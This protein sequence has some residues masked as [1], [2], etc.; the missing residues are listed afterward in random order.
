LT[1]KTNKEKLRFTKAANQI[2]KIVPAPGFQPS[3]AQAKTFVASHAAITERFNTEFSE[4]DALSD[5][6]K[7]TTPAPNIQKIANDYRTDVLK[8]IPQKDIDAI[9][10]K[11]N[12][13]FK[14]KINITFDEN[15]DIRVIADNRSAYG[16]SNTE[17]DDIKKRMNSIKRLKE[18]R[19]SMR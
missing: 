8:S 18:Q 14:D 3:Q 9:L 10:G 13:E 2:A 15:T 19:D 1:R 12:F 11:L 5:D 7:R 6:Q 17:I 4:W 16:L